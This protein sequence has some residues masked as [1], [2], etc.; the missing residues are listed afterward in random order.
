[1]W[2]GSCTQRYALGMSDSVFLSCQNFVRGE[3]RQLVFIDRPELHNT[4]EQ[5]PTVDLSFE[6]LRLFSACKSFLFTCVR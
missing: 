2:G 1:M 3:P 5:G 4:E 6:S